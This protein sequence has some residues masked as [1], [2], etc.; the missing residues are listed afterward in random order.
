M[1]LNMT[2]V[3]RSALL[4]NIVYIAQYNIN[5]LS[6]RVWRDSDQRATYIL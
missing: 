3:Y 1:I 6:R 2:R 4:H 5:D